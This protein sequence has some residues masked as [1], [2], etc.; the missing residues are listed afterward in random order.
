M[1]WKHQDGPSIIIFLVACTRLYNP[2]CPSVCR[3]VGR[4]HLA[5]STFTGG[6]GVT[7]P[8]QL[9]SW[10]ILSLPLPIRTRLGQPYIRPC[11]SL[12]LVQRFF[13]S[14][15]INLWDEFFFVSTRGL[16]TVKIISHQLSPQFYSSDK[17]FY[18]QFAW[19]FN[20]L[21]NHSTISYFKII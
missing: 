7:A 17:T 13:L 1:Y 15:L 3:S 12:K 10:S 2:L 20:D 19:L 9:P 4:W 5:F 6:F 18:T 11:Y 16:W 14:W 8:A 21:L